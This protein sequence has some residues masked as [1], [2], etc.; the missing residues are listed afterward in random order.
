MN[1]VTE[2]QSS[3][4]EREQEYS[5]YRLSSGSSRP[6]AVQV[7]LNGKSVEMEVDTGAS[8]SII[9]EET[10]LI[11]HLRHGGV[12][13]PP[14]QSA[15][16]LCTYR[17]QTIQVVGSTDVEV[18]H[19]GQRATL[20]LLVTRGY[21]GLFIYNRLPF[22]VSSAPLIFKRVMENLLQ[23]IPGVSV[24]MDDILVTGPTDEQ[25]LSQLAEVLHRL[26]DAGVKLKKSK[27]FFLLPSV[28][29]LGHTISSEGLH[30]SD[31][32]VNGIL[33]A[34]APTSVSELWSFLGLINYYGK[35]LPDLATTLAPL[36]TL[37]QKKKKWPWG[38]SQ[39]NAFEQVKKLLKS[40][41]VLVHFNDDL[42]LVLAC[43]ASPYGLRAVLS[44][45]MPNGDERP[46]G[47]ASRTLTVAE[48]KYSQLDKE[49][50]AIVFGVNKYHQYLY[51]RKFELKTDHKP[52]T[53]IFSP[54]KVTPPMASGRIQRWA[55]T[56]GAYSY[57]IQHKKGE[58]NSN[59]DA[60]SRLPQPS[61]Q[62][63]PPQPGEV[64]LL[65]EHLNSTPL[66]SDKIK[67]WTTKDPVL[68]KVKAW[69]QTGWPDGMTS[70]QQELQPFV[71][72]KNELSV[73]TGCILWGNRVVIP[74]RGREQV[75]TLIHEAHPGISQ[76]K[77]LAR[78]YFWWPGIDKQL[79]NCVKLCETCQMHQKSSPP[80]FFHPWSWPNKPWSRV[81]I[82]Y[83]GPFLGK[84]F[85]MMIDAHTKR[86]E[87]HMTTSS[88]SSTTI[89]LLQKTF[90]ALGLPDVIVSDNGSNFFS[91]EF[92]DFLKKNGVKHIRTA[93][94]HP[95]SN[96]LAE[97][98]VQTF[99]EGMKKLIEGTLETKLA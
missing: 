77:S 26:K 53:H 28:E 51:G 18:E 76:M 72:R 48:K 10:H 38:Q 94:Y 65:M 19:N 80:S 12:T 81:H 62:E 82:D 29:Y 34:P 52:L 68:S 39:Q 43:D 55:L 90:A 91:D 63:D 44:H 42:P 16:K 22:G 88:T 47:F 13:I 85:L 2:P 84:M 6:I 30:T 87:V 61:R 4:E 3:E 37:L 60:L 36:Y 97:R 7:S 57:M 33:K 71:R 67:E 83:A 99:K 8:V 66:T 46:V 96:G 95:V 75:V 78:S 15:A 98:A 21:K 58:E 27:C 79:E 35:F 11:Q 50:L 40:S 1:Q 31:A 86:M 23:G 32:K 64:I 69:V 89:S 9:S 70:V 45:R 56:L 25:H 41:R 24:Y 14:T 54:S 20:P 73:E 49:A 17:G 93:P 92:A 74:T 59:A 5:L